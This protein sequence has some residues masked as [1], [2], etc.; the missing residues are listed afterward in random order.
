MKH[1]RKGPP[2]FSLVKWIPRKS[3]LR[4]RRL[5]SGRVYLFLGEIRNMPGHCAVVDVKSGR[6]IVGYHSD[7]FVELTA[8]E[9]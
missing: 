1:A 7:T 6:T 3:D 2:Q 9:V 5:Q 8:E 4:D